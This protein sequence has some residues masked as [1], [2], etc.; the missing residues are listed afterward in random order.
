[1][2]RT[3]CD[4]PLLVPG[5]PYL[6]SDQFW[7]AQER[8]APVPGVETDPPLNESCALGIFSGYQQRRHCA[9]VSHASSQVLGTTL[10]ANL[11]LDVNL[12]AFETDATG[13][14]VMEYH[15]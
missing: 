1:M 6:N 9:A 12:F 3:P 8:R 11:L 4:L 10:I 2:S 14:T 15:R 13:R 7:N 5:D